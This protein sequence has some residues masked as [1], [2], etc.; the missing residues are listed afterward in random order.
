MSRLA[1]D[2]KPVSDL[3]AKERF[4]KAKEAFETP[5]EKQ[6][7]VSGQDY[8]LSWLSQLTKDGS[9]R[10]EKTINNVVLIL[11]NDPILKRKI[12]TDEFAACGMVL[13]HLPWDSR[14]EK[15][16]WTEVDDA[17]FY[18]YIEAFYLSLI[19]I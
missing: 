2:D 14:E 16:R 13:G 3:L 9:G 11:E 17:G 1:L 8:D 18:R 12:V 4:E 10:F 6:G 7:G 15:R 5:A 19:H